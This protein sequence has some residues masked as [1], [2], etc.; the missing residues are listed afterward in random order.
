MEAVL[1]GKIEGV[2]EIL[3]SALDTL[4]GSLGSPSPLSPRPA[5]FLLGYIASSTAMLEH[6]RW[7]AL[8]RSKAEH[9]VDVDTLIRWVKYDGLAAAQ[10]ELSTAAAF[11]HEVNERLVYGINAEVKGKL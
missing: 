3:V 5:L 1:R 6:T 7:S 8:H 11:D 4:I 10:K 9:E 2:G